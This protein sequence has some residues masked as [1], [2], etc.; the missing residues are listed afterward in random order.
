MSCVWRPTN[1][2][3]LAGLFEDAAV[4]VLALSWSSGISKLFGSPSWSRVE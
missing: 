4:L 2:A 1:V 3:F